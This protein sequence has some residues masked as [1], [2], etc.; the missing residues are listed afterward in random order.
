MRNKNSLCVTLDKYSLAK[1][2]WSIE[3]NNLNG[4]ICNTFGLYRSIYTCNHKRMFNVSF[5]YI[6]VGPSIFRLKLTLTEITHTAVNNFSDK[7]FSCLAKNNYRI[8]PD[9]YYNTPITLWTEI[10]GLKNNYKEDLFRP[11]KSVKRWV[12]ANFWVDMDGDPAL[13]PIKLYCFLFIKLKQLSTGEM[14]TLTLMS[15]LFYKQTN[16]DVEFRFRQGK[17]SQRD[18]WC[19]SIGAHTYILEDRS[20][21]FA[22][23]FKYDMQKEGDSKFV[24]IKYSNPAMFKDMLAYIYSG[25]LLRPIKNEKFARVLCELAD[26]FDIYDLKGLCINYLLPL[27]TFGNVMYYL[28]WGY[29]HSDEVMENALYTIEG[30]GK[31]IWDQDEW[32]LLQKEYPTLYEIAD[33]R[34]STPEDA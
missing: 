4:K 3:I 25:R 7:D 2:N 18:N 24:W 19:K 1:V 27:V 5:S 16:C 31:E 21:V 9:D 17:K 6:Y 22:A 13:K 12:T 33:K 32:D 10:F 34:T 30:M 8:T 14:N 29:L 20:K 26:M 15:N 11:R 23:L 28:V